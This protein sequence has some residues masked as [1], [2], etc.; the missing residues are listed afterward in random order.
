MSLNLRAPR[1]LGIVSFVLLLIG[2]L[3]SLVFYTQID[4]VDILRDS[5]I[6]A[7]NTD[8]AYQEDLGL[9]NI[10]STGEEFADELIVAGKKFLLLPVIFSI[11]ACAATLFSVIMMNK[12]PRTSGILFIIVGV[13]SLLSIIIPILLITAGV[14]I[15]NRWSRYNKEAGIPA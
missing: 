14:M 3:L 15:L 4:K 2:F 1:I 10:P 13:V 6:D 12:M 11:I 7:Y 9:E 5:L 8:P